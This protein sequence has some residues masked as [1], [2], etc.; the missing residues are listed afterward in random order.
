LIAVQKVGATAVWISIVTESDDSASNRIEKL[1]GGLIVITWAGTN[2][3]CSDKDRIGCLRH[4]DST[5]D[6]RNEE[7]RKNDGESR[8]DTGSADRG[9][10]GH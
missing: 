1:G 4:R 9:M 10:G 2:V 6:K 8:E 3:T 7:Q 5:T